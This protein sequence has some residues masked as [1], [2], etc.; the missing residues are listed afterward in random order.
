MKVNELFEAEEQKPVELTDIV[1]YFP[2]NAQKA[3]EKLLQ[4]DRLV[5]NGKPFFDYYHEVVLPRA[6]A[7]AK[8]S[9]YELTF[10]IEGDLVHVSVSADEVQEVYCGYS[11]KS[12]VFIVGFDVW[13]NNQDF[14]DAFEKHFH[15]VTGRQFDLDDDEE[16]YDEVWEAYKTQSMQGFA[17]SIYPN[18]RVAEYEESFTGGFYKAGKAQASIKNVFPDVIDLRLD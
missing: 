17:V 7:L 2:N 13:T 12:G 4:N 9:E 10:P 1:K 15:A 16:T 3:A 6:E 5:V 18:G 14:D 11:Q 8:K